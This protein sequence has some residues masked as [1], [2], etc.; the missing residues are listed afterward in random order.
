MYEKGYMS[1][2]LLPKISSED[3]WMK[4]LHSE[5]AEDSQQIQSKSKTQFSRTSRPVSEQPL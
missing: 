3:N 5:V 1:P 2:Q 4:E